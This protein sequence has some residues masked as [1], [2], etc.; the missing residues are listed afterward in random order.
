M[1]P[2]MSRRSTTLPRF[3]MTSILSETLAPPRMATQ[4]RARIG[5]GHAEVLQF[6][7]HQQAGGGLLDEL[8]HALGG[9][10]GAV[11]G[12]E[13]VV[14]VDVAEGGQFLGE[15]GIVLF[16]FGVEAQIFEQQHF[17]GRGLHGLHFGADA[18][19][20]H[21]DRAIEQ[22]LQPRGHG[23]VDSFRDSASLWDGRGATPG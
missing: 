6:L 14:D 2:P 8:D 23:L 3:W 1:A 9:S 4:G 21:F 5:G 17:A 16:F 13:R 19:G 10:V 18:I 22:L 15:G 20:R 12:A 11:R 7:L